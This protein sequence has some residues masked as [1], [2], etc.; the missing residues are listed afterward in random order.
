MIEIPELINK[1]FNMDINLT[2]AGEE[3]TGLVNKWYTFQSVI[4]FSIQEIH[5]HQIHYC[6][7]NVVVLSAGIV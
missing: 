7:G 6:A 4:V 5:P 3:Y 1:T 2:E